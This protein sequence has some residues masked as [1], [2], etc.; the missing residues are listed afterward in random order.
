MEIIG[1]LFII[2][3]LVIVVYGACRWIHYIFTTKEMTY[4]AMCTS[5]HIKE[6]GDKIEW[7]TD[8]MLKKVNDA[9]LGMYKSF[10]GDNEVES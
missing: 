9:A 5:Y 3:T 7:L 1:Y 8:D 6:V 4:D 2:A 10:T